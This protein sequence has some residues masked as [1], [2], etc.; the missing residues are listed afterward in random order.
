LRKDWWEAAKHPD[1]VS[2][3]ETL[4]ITRHFLND[5]SR[6]YEETLSRKPTL[7]KLE[8]TLNLAFQINVTD[9]IV[10]TS[11]SWR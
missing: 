10:P 8:Y 3:D 9:E 6:E 2:G 5:L 7:A 1:I 11:M 4:D